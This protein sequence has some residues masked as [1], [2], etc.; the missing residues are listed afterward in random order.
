M[1]SCLQGR[2]QA[3]RTFRAKIFTNGR[4]KDRKAIRH[5]RER[6]AT[7]PLELDLIRRVRVRWMGSDNWQGNL[8]TQVQS[9]IHIRTDRDRSSVTQLPR[10]GT[11]LVTA[12]P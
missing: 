6:R 4:S 2:Q 11:K 8:R 9:E 10:P 7:R 1:T 12:V 3:E 5:T